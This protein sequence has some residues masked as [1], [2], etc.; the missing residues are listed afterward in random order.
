MRG[1]G[2]SGAALVGQGLGKPGF[3]SQLRSVL[4][5]PGPSFCLGDASRHDNRSPNPPTHAA[6]QATVVPALKSAQGLLE[7]RLASAAAFDD[8]LD[9]YWLPRVASAI[10]TAHY[11]EHQLRCPFWRREGDV[12]GKGGGVIHAGG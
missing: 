3:D 6:A 4:S 11:L 9:A 10:C 12:F 8:L 1:R 2:P 5:M 7:R